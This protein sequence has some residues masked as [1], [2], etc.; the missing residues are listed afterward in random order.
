MSRH[1]ALEIKFFFVGGGGGG[2]GTLQGALL[3]C[4]VTWMECGLW[5]GVNEC[6]GM[7]V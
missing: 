7:V 6:G 3:R 1:L 5:E 2:E 4:F